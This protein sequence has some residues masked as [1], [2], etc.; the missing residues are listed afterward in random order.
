M[1]NY[2]LIKLI[3]FLYLFQDFWIPKIIRLWPSKP[4]QT[5]KRQQFMLLIS[6]LQKYAWTDNWLSNLIIAISRMFGHYTFSRV[7]IIIVLHNKVVSKHWSF[8]LLRL[9]CNSVNLPYNHAW[10][11]V[12]LSRLMF[13]VATWNFWISYKNRYAGL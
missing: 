8:S 11:T 6:I 12:V 2:M 4:K 5:K 1:F 13:L 10:N 9:L 3:L 7:N